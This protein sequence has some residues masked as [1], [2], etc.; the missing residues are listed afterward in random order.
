MIGR[1]ASLE[2]HGHWSHATAH[3]RSVPTPSCASEARYNLAL[4]QDVSSELLRAG[5]VHTSTATRS[6]FTT[7]A[8]KPHGQAHTHIIARLHLQGRSRRTRVCLS[9]DS[10]KKAGQRRRPSHHLLTPAASS[11]SRG[12]AS[13]DNHVYPSLPIACR[14]RQLVT[15]A[16]LL[17]RWRGQRSS[18]SEHKRCLPG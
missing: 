18:N 2:R 17:P 15:A 14:G 12:T 8:S 6:R 13:A 4:N 7:A 9:D 5:R 10:Y 3:G 16:A 1:L 11:V